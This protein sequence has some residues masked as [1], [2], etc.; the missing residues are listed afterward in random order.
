MTNISTKYLGLELR[1]PIIVGSSGLTSNIENIKEIA[2]NGAGAIVLK[3]IFEEE[4]LLESQDALK[5][6][7]KDKLIYKELSETLD[8]VDLHI[9]EKSLNNYLKLI[10]EAKKSVSIPVIASINCISDYEWINFA[11]KIQ[12]AGADALELNIF[13]NPAD[14]IKKDSEKIQF[15]IIKKVLK[16]VSIPVAVKISNCDSNLAVT[17]QKI[18]E[19][20]VAGVVL[21]NRFYSPDFDIENF[22]V[23]S[24]NIFS[25]AEEQV[26]PLRWISL[27][28]GKVN[29]SL[30]A[31]TG[32]HHSDAVIKQILAGA[33]AV[34]IVSTL[35]LNGI[36]YLKKI[37]SD[38]EQWMITKG[39]FSLD[40]IKGQ[41]SYK[42]STNPAIYERMQFM[43][44]YS[45]IG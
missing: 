43:K 33:D 2:E 31:S 36:K 30:A 28:S 13:L 38:M 34:Q 25:N 27:M 4:I 7:H 17:I 11:I 18:A 9:N 10:K 37:H 22:T 15:S 24:A 39:V 45:R 8:Y 14:F 16:T 40:Q 32:I 1:S 41:M 6:A 12:E 26:K 44:R 19:T 5:E 42:R 20:G 35:Y 29:C 21:F 3:S 23:S